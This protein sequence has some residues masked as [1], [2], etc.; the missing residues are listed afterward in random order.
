MAEILV[1]GATGKTG[2]R[3]TTKLAAQGHRVRA[4]AR[5][6]GPAAPGVTPVHFAWEDPATHREALA[7][8]DAVYV[9]PPAFR[10]DHPPLIRA[11]AER[12]VAAGV[13]RLVLLS[14][15]GADADEASPLFQAEQAV[16][17]AG[18]EWTV[19]RPSWFAQNFTEGF[20]VPR[21]GVIAA[22]AGDG[23]TPF[24]DA[25]DIAD[26]VAAALTGDGH[27]GQVY[28]LSGPEA[29]TWA[30]AADTLAQA[31]GRPVRYADAEPG[32][33]VREA[34]AGGAPAAY[35]ELLAMLFGAIRDGHEA[36]LSDGVQRALGRPATSFAAFAEREAGVLRDAEAAAAR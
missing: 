25:Q 12:A 23:P 24:V 17:D 2:R 14:A 16:R 35:M 34:V 11:F 32:A 26:V 31:S 28:E 19:V 4:A 15:R 8:A 7:F 29:L 3:V 10:L 1:L 20:L 21:D 13:T 36:P 6:P 27:A 9:I 5:T 22:P 30:Q 33:W 18:A